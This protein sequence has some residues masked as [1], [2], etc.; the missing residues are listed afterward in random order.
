MR[1]ILSLLIFLSIQVS[2][3]SQGLDRDLSAT[4]TFDG[5]SAY[6]DGYR[7]DVLFNDQTNTYNATDLEVGDILIESINFSVYRIDTIYT[8]FLSR[9]EVYI[10][11]LSSNGNSPSG[12]GQ[13]ER[14]TS[15][16]GLSLLTPANQNGISP[17]LFSVIN[18]HNMLLIDSLGFQAVNDGNGIYS[19]SDTLSGNTTIEANSSIL[20]IVNTDLFR[21]VDT[22]G[23]TELRFSDDGALRYLSTTGITLLDNSLIPKSYVDSL[24]PRLTPG[25]VLF[26]NSDSTITSD[27]SFVFSSNNLGI[28]KSS[29]NFT[30]DVV[31]TVSFPSIP[32]GTSYE[33][34]LTRDSTTGQIG[35]R[36]RNDMTGTS[37]SRYRYYTVDENGILED[38]LIYVSGGNIS[39]SDQILI[40]SDAGSSNSNSV[41]Q[42]A[43]GLSSGSSNTGS[44]QIAIG[45]VAG[46]GNSGLRQISIGTL[47]G[48]EN[49]GANQ[50][51]IG[52]SAGRLNS[53]GF[54]IAI[55]SSAG[56][57]NKALHQVAIG[58][59]S[60]R[61]NQG[62]YNISIGSESG[63]SVSRTLS[64]SGDYNIWL[65]NRSG[66][67]ITE[68]NNNI[69]MGRESGFSLTT[70]NRNIYLGSFSS[71]SDTLV[72]NEIAL[73]Y[74]VTGS[75]DSTVTLGGSINKMLVSGNYKWNTD[76]DTT[77]LDG[78]VQTFNAS[79]GEL[80][81]QVLPSTG[82]PVTYNAGNGA[83]V[84]ASALG[85]TFSKN[86][87][88]GEY[89]FTIPDGV[90]LYYITVSGSNGDTDVNG[91]LYVAFNY[92]G[93]RVFNQG[94][95]TAWIPKVSVWES[96]G[97]AP[98]RSSPKT[99]LPI[100]V[101]GISSVGSGNVEIALQNVNTITPNPVFE[102]R[103]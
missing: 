82:T 66:Y 23:E 3:F 20:Q 91:E 103:F 48:G 40:G 28:G 57:E 11:E 50:I 9:A 32:D 17:Q 25:T 44:E 100:N 55:G 58:H 96:G 10:E 70:G 69:G 4:V 76:Q 83:T 89:T 37:L 71:P 35:Y 75:G 45:T 54:Q 22:D 67:S 81:L 65:G 43:I 86:S 46:S 52:S 30:L 27:T 102:F 34:V 94:L 60:G 7:G 84:T 85:V 99:I 36:L 41:N 14:R 18:S 29:P 90:I 95:S 6:A 12:R 64:S 56:S 53:S 15:N 8:A 21:L 62:S 16:L 49:I 93:T 38:G 78:Y 42:I 72:N 26:M 31:G 88:T 19:G 47:A 74:N 87:T 63:Y 73:G 24:V 77:G 5:F 39:P 92:S 68:G 1:L 97:S 2:L 98:S 13:A 51:A 59:E 80:E 33:H 79:T 61:Y 101:Q